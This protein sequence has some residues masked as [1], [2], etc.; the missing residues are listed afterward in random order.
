MAVIHDKQEVTLLYFNHDDARLHNQ[1]LTLPMSD[2]GR[3]IIPPAL[4]CNKQIVGV[5]EGRC[6]LVN[7]AD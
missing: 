6:Q 3:P 5:V 7:T 1:T 2:A 4:R